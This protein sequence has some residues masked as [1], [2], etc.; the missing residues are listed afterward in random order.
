MSRSGSG[1]HVFPSQGV[2]LLS[3]PGRGQGG[4]PTAQGV[5]MVHKGKEIAGEQEDGA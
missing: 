1:G 4:A 3:P 2:V 5:G